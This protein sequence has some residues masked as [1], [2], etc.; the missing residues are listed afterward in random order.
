MVKEANSDALSPA[1]Q[2]HKKLLSFWAGV[3]LGILSYFWGPVLSPKG[4]SLF[5]AQDSPRSNAY[6]EPFFQ[7]HRALF[8][9]F[10]LQV[11]YACMFGAL[12]L[13]RPNHRQAWVTAFLL[14]LT[15]PVLCLRAL[16]VL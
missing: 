14:G 5:S 11:L 3:A 12:L 7:L 16:H 13:F 4:T 6:L 2:S 9:Y 10:P 1:Q 15:I 8:E